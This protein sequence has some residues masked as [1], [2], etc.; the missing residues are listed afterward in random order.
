MSL[1]DVAQRTGELVK[2]GVKEFSD[3]AKSF[4]NAVRNRVRMM[5]GSFAE[6]LFSSDVDNPSECEELRRKDVAG[7]IR[8]V[9]GDDPVK[10]I[11]EA[12]SSE[13][14]R[15]LS[16]LVHC[17]AEALK[18]PPPDMEVQIMDAWTAGMYRFDLDRIVINRCEVDRTPMGVDEAVELI[19][20]VLHEMYHAFQRHAIERPLKHNVSKD[21]AWEWRKNFENYICYEQSPRLYWKQPVEE[22]AR[23]FAHAVMVAT[24]RD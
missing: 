18:I 23:N 11:C 12:D 13:R 5:A 3:W 24:S 22:S 14:E 4:W 8:T 16:A 1:R 20:T 6:L 17:T 7:A 10:T 21:Q 15:M 19:D 2:R 9:L